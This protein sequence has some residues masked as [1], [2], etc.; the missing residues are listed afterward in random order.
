MRI[1]KNS[2]PILRASAE[3]LVETKLTPRKNK[4]VMLALI[5]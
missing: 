3:H 2:S 4:T 1:V 5:T